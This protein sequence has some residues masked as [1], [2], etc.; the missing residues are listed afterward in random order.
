MA[1]NMAMSIFAATATATPV[2]PIAGIGLI[3]LAYGKLASSAE[4]A[5]NQ[6]NDLQRTGSENIKTAN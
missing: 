2:E 4:D 6:I 5:K 3:A 1:A